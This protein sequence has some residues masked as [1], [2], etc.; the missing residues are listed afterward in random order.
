MAA[1]NDMEDIQPLAGALDGRRAG[2]LAHLIIG[3]LVQDGH[4]QP[5]ARALMTAVAR[6]SV[7]RNVSVY[8]QAATQQLLTTSSLYF[9][10][11]V[12]T[13]QWTLLGAEVRAKSTRFDLVWTS[14]TDKAV[15]VDEI[16]TGRAAT[17]RDRAAVEEQLAR[18]LAAGGDAYGDSF[19]GV[20]V[21][22]LA[23]PRASFLARPSGQ[24]IDVLGGER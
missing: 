9:R 6:H 20:R 15:L 16:K 23:A 22:W 2:Q 1:T 4:R 5:D 24:R 10:L 14:E 17:S 11:F 18:Q 3:E 7:T 21:L 8:R 12:P 19:L 13:S